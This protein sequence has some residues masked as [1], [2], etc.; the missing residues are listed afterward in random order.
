M[1]LKPFF[2]MPKLAKLL[3]EI[4]RI[5][6]SIYEILLSGPVSIL[7]E[8]RRY[9]IHFARFLPALLACK[10]WQM[11]ATI[12]TPW[13]MSAKLN[14]SDKDGFSSHLP[15]PEEFD[16]SVEVAFAVKFGPE[17]DGWKLIR[18]GAILHE[19]QTTFVPDFVFR[20]VD[21]TE[22]LMEI[23]GFWTPEYLAHRRETLRT[24]KHHTILLAIPEKSLKTDAV[25][26]NNIVTYKKALLLKP[27]VEALEAIRRT[28]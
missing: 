8:S 19:N 14:L 2:G 4:K 21:G 17:R 22:V 7:H 18:E 25:P 28:V 16:S 6:P 10:G 11:S 12:K 5:G 20:H 3:H 27:V 15:S 13:N 24:F 1:I 23:I 26:V 9:G